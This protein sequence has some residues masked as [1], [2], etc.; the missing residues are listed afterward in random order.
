MVLFGVFLPCRA[1]QQ[2]RPGNPGRRGINTTSPPSYRFFFSLYSNFTNSEICLILR[3]VQITHRQNVRYRLTLPDPVALL[4]HT[5]LDH[6]VCSN[7][8]CYGRQLCVLGM[9]P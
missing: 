2:Q 7:I 4:Y 6:L 1:P 3:G 5:I 9:I 8:E